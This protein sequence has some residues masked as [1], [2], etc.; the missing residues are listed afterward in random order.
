MALLPARVDLNGNVLHQAIV[1][2]DFPCLPFPHFHSLVQGQEQ[3]FCGHCL[4]WLTSNRP[5]VTCPCEQGCHMDAR[6][7]AEAG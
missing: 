1:V 3:D 4:H 5:M 6:E 2:C 7:L